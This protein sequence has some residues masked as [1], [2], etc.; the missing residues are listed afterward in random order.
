M[1]VAIFAHG[2]RGDIQPYIALALGLRSHGADVRFI[3]PTEYKSLAKEYALPIHP[4]SGCV[5]DVAQSE[6]MRSLLEKGSFVRIMR[7]AMH[8]LKEAAPLWAAEGLEACAGCDFIISGLGGLYLA[9]ALSEKLRIPLVQAFLVPFSPTSAFPG[10]L[11]PPRLAISGRAFN[12]ISHHLVRQVMW[13]TMRKSDALVR[14]VLHVP[15]TS[16]WG[17]YHN[18]VM[19][20]SRTMYGFSVGL[21]PR[22]ADWDDSIAI[23]GYWFLDEPGSWSPPDAL[24]EFISSG[25]KPVYIGFGSMSVLDPEE[26]KTII[27][28]AVNECGLRAVVHSSGT[29]GLLESPCDNIHVVDSVPHSWLFPQMSAVV[30]HGGA[31]TTGA[32]LRAGV[33]SLIVPFFGDQ[34]FWGARIADAALGPKPLP[35]KSLTKDNLAKAILQTVNTPAFRRNASKMRDVI[36]GEDGTGVAYEVL[37]STLDTPKI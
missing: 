37:R 20:E 33:P 8:K 36:R 5:K 10:A 21:I 12:R 30:H 29:G 15:P 22:P 28:G 4:L 19:R 9:A 7:H 24:T 25:D 3:A 6:E 26:L 34:P 27:V 1:R 31:G 23:T 32:G 18:E 16:F 11:V 2:T 14:E 17:P 35:K 13:Q